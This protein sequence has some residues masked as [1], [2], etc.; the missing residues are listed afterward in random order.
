MVEGLGLCI[1]LVRIARAS[2]VENATLQKRIVGT[3]RFPW[4]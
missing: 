3:T 1:M 4:G 2:K